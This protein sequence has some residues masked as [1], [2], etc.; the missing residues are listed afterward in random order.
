MNSRRSYGKNGLKRRSAESV[1]RDLSTAAT[2]Q[3]SPSTQ[4][5]EDVEVIGYNVTTIPTDTDFVSFGRGVLHGTAENLSYGQF[6]D[7][8]V[9]GN[10]QGHDLLQERTD[11]RARMTRMEEKVAQLDKEVA[12]IPRLEVDMA[13]LR[14]LSEGYLRIRERFLDVF[15]RDVL[16]DSS[17]QRLQTITAGNSA[18]HDADAVADALVYEYGRRRDTRLLTRIYGL[19]HDQ[20]LSLHY[21]GNTDCIE[22]LN[23]QANLV[24]N[25]QISIPADAGDAFETFLTALENSRADQMPSTDPNSILGQAYVNFWKVLNAHHL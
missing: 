5:D 18:A 6:G 13:R 16:H 14:G 7:R 25:R 12:K 19:G 8:L 9:I 22:V 17:A 2:P 24:I 10:Q 23:K 11:L 4:K 3:R 15:R 21:A 1:S 20:I